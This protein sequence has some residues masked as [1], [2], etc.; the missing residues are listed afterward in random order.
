V[1][2]YDGINLSICA[3]QYIEYNGNAGG[4]VRFRTVPDSR[5]GGSTLAYAGYGPCACTVPGNAKAVQAFFFPGASLVG[6]S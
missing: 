5:S 1:R 3:L 2:Y 4:G 6:Q